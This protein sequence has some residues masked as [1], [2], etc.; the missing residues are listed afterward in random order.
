MLEFNNFS[1]V[2]STLII[3]ITVVV[4]IFAKNYLAGD[5]QQSNF[6]IKLSLLSSSLLL[7][8]NAINPYLLAI[9]HL[10]SN[11]LLSSLMI[12]NNKWQAARNSGVFTAINLSTASLIL[13]IGLLLLKNQEFIGLTLI[14]TAA[15][16]QCSL[17]PFHKWL[18]G[19]LNSP[20]PVSAFMHAG[21]INGGG[22]ILI[23]HADLLIK[24]EALMLSIFLIGSLSALLGGLGMLTKPDIKSSL[25]CSTMGQMGFMFVQCGLGLFPMALGHMCWHG[26]Y[27][28][29]LFLNS[30]SAIRSQFNRKDIKSNETYKLVISLFFGLLMS[31]IFSKICFNHFFKPDGTAIIQGFVALS[32]AQVLF[33]AWKTS[34]PTIGLIVFSLLYP[35]L[36]T[37]SVVLIEKFLNYS[38]IN[39]AAELNPIH[40]IIL[41]LFTL[42]WFMINIKTNLIEFVPSKLRTMVYIKLVNSCQAI[43]NG[44]TK[45]RGTL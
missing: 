31:L 18:L 40:L 43:G 11:L 44:I 2:I 9:S 22:L 27:K 3:S 42:F 30:G 37:S 12:H 39:H 7:F 17:Y 19:S 16:I 13:F 29:Y 20:T 33:T 15:A 6:Y 25:A 5:Q 24:H 28:A 34:L 36:Y 23:K 26:F 35:A 45:T 10:S 4:A 38:I 14:I 32:F 1:L 21:L 41:G 8:A